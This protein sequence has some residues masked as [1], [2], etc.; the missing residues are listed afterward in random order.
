MRNPIAI[1]ILLVVCHAVNSQSKITL[2]Q[3]SY[4]GE[5]PVN[6]VSP[7][8]HYQAKNNWYAEARYN[9]E[10]AQTF[11][12]YAGRTFAKE[13]RF[14]YS[15]T[16]MVGGMTG[17]LKAAALGLNM[18]LGFDNFSFSSQ[19]QYALMSGNVSNNFFFSWSELSY[20]PVSWLYGGLSLQHTQFYRSTA[21]VEPGVL[22]GF[23]F[24]Q[25]T[26]PVYGFLPY[27]D[28]R[29]FIIGIGYEW[30]HNGNKKIKTPPSY[31]TQND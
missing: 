4:V 21:L 24:K 28:N 16:P 31:L 25:W 12:L 20:R 19:S 8:A 23:S 2:E 30:T 15:F 29:Y 6:T 13:S 10:E 5:K 18:E 22:L 7:I 3:Y 17:K 14:S 27:A 9:Y 11:S 26:I 1:T